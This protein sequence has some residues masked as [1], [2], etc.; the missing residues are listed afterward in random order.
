MASDS[1]RTATGNVCSHSR[2]AEVSSLFGCCARRWFAWLSAGFFM[3]T[4]GL[5]QHGTVRADS[6][7]PILPKK[8]TDQ[9]RRILA[10]WVDPTAMLSY[11]RE[12]RR[13]EPAAYSATRVCRWRQLLCSASTHC[14]LWL[15]IC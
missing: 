3:M 1:G 4:P 13:A 10:L 2:V 6:P 7:H 9:A 11:C 12:V 5:V 8:T 14:A 15:Q